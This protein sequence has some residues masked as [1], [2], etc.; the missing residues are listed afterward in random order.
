[1]VSARWWRVSVADCGVVSV[2]SRGVA[3]D[4][5]ADRPLPLAPV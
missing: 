2:A 1:V 5:G 3:G 4:A